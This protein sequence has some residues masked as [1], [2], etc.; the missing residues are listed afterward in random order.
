V[1][2]RASLTWINGPAPAGPYARRVITKLIA[3]VLLTSGLGLAAAER[4]DLTGFDFS[5][6]PTQG[7]L[8]I[9]FKDRP[10]LLYAFA[11]NQFKP[12]VREL[13]TLKG[14][15]VLVDAPPDHLH[16]HGLMYAIRVNGVNF[17][18]ERDQP[19]YERSVRVEAP[20]LGR[21]PEGLPQ[22][23]FTERVHWVSSPNAAAADTEA[24]SLLVEKRTLTLTVDEKKDEVALS[25]RGDFEVGPQVSKVTLAGAN[26]HGLGLRLPAA[27][28]RVA[29]HRNSED[30]PYTN[31]GRGDTTPARWSSVAHEIGARPI[32]VALFGRPSAESGMPVFFTMTE[33]FTYLSVTQGLDKKPLDYSAGDKFKVEY[34][35]TVYSAEVTPAFLNERQRLWAR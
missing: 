9:N 7:L 33:P 13:Y 1:V 23:V 6:Q 15:N 24:V 3:T 32:T 16:H 17:W 30:T 34:L 19:G 20:R 21:S 31:N 29:R 28:N 26:Y 10:L 25:W 4:S 27:F 14:D 12:Y 2:D 18:E 22:A 5:L 11:S 8:Q 35:L